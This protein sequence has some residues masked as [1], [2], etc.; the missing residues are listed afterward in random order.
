MFLF[1]YLFGGQTHSH[2][3]FKTKP[4]IILYTKNTHDCE[5]LEYAGLKMWDEILAD[6]FGNI[7][8]IFWIFWTS[9]DLSA[10]SPLLDKHVNFNSYKFQ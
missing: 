4:W 3:R 5:R 9:F 1:N 10:H 8:I 7:L 2:E 6:W